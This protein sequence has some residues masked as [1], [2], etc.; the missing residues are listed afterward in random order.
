[1]AGSAHHVIR[2]SNRFPKLWWLPGNG[3]GNGL[4]DSAWA[5]I[6]D[7]R[8]E[9]VADWVLAALLD[10]GAPAYAA[11]LPRQQSRRSTAT[12][13]GR[14]HMRPPVVRIWVGASAH[15]TAEETILQRLP[16]L[17]DRFGASAIR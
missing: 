10:V 11:A 14:R 15:A 8:D 7:V 3:Y 1:M 6:L 17:I 2:V 13:P 4:E 16:A 9:S 12:R 5:A